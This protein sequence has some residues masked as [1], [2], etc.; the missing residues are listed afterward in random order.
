MESGAGALAQ[1]NYYMGIPQGTRTT[2][3]TGTAGTGSTPAGGMGPVGQVVE[4]PITKQQL[5][6]AYKFNGGDPALADS[7]AE[8]WLTELNNAP[9]GMTRDA[10]TSRMNQLFPG[11]APELAAQVA[12]T[13]IS[14]RDA[15]DIQAML[16]GGSGGGSPETYNVQPNTSIGTPGMLAEGFDAEKFA[17][18]DWKDPGYDFRMA[19]GQKALERS[20]SARG[21][22]LSGGALKSL[23]RYS[24]GVASD[25][26]DKSFT[27]AFN[28]F[29][30]NDTNLFNRLSLLAGN[31]QQ[32]TVQMG[33]LGANYAGSVGDNLARAAAA[34][35]EYA[36]QGANARASGYVGAA[37][38]WNRGAGTMFN[39]IGDIW[40][41]YSGQPY[42]PFN[43]ASPPGYSST[44]PGQPFT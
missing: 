9:S 22:L 35:G 38:A 31:G 6:D 27:R 40:G 18:G 25:E 21:S 42:E 12:D 3:P 29:N 37:N 43:F 39:N 7:I 20:A 2:T 15:A 13:A 26:Y 14:N 33:N 44:Y 24:Q 4:L 5:I 30:A 34:G 41:S 28:T 19:E 23:T 8:Q 16:P 32:A 1:L 36:T 11:L 17:A 10:L